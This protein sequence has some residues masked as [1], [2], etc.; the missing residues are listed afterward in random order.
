MLVQQGRVFAND[1]SGAVAAIREKHGAGE[2]SIWQCL[3]QPQ[4]GVIWFE[5]AIELNPNGAQ[6]PKH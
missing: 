3:V 6:G 2:L 5:Y 1:A 4:K